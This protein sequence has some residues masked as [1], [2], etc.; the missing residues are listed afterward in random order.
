MVKS[1]I[2]I[3]NKVAEASLKSEFKRISEDSF[4]QAERVEKAILSTLELARQNPERYPKDKF[5]VENKGNFR[6]FEAHSYRVAY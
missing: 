6:A 1:P 2:V 5:K 4:I 3:W